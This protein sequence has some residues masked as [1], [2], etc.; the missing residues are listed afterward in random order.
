MNKLLLIIF[1]SISCSFSQNKEPFKNKKSTLKYLENLLCNNAFY[2]NISF[3]KL[4]TIIYHNKNIFNIKSL[5]DQIEIQSNG[6]IMLNADENFEELEIYSLTQKEQNECFLIS[7]LLKEFE[8]KDIQT[9]FL[10]RKEKEIFETTI[11]GKI[12]KNNTEFQI[13]IKGEKNNFKLDELYINSMPQTVQFYE[14]D[15]DFFLKFYGKKSWKENSINLTYLDSIYQELIVFY[16]QKNWE[17][18]DFR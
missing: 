18:I 10:N 12:K 9:V 8:I 13:K 6:K 4:N 5:S 16:K 3:G 11:K 15:K 14:E 1:F 17:I 7:K 2:A